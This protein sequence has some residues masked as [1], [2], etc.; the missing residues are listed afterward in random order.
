MNLYR[1]IVSESDDELV[2]ILNDD[3]LPWQSNCD[4]EGAPPTSVDMFQNTLI[5]YIIYPPSINI[6]YLSSLNMFYLSSFKLVSAS[7]CHL[8][9]AV[10]DRGQYSSMEVNEYWDK[11]FWEENSWKNLLLYR[12]YKFLK[13]VKNTIFLPKHLGNIHP[14]PRTQVCPSSL[15]SEDEFKRAS[16]SRIHNSIYPVIQ[17]MQKWI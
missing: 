11:A 16:V 5:K 14:C 12:T 9:L 2:V 8:L 7:S 17:S 1:Y 10:T 13:T 3:A 4:N 15:I 6:S